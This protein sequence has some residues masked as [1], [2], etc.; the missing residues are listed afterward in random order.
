MSQTH[1]KDT[2]G[3]RNMTR[4]ARVDFH[5]HTQRAPKGFEYGFNL[6]V[7]ILTADV[8]D[9]DRYHGVI[10]KALKKFTKQIHIKIAH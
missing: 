3:G 7:S 5:R 6:V 10:N 4:S 2:F 8:I 1:L 9:V